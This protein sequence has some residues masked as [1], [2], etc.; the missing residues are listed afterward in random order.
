MTAKENFEAFL[1]LQAEPGYSLGDIEGSKEADM[2]KYTELKIAVAQEEA[3]EKDFSVKKEAA[4][5]AL[6]ESHSQE[7]IELG[8]LWQLKE[9]AGF[10]ADFVP[11]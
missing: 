11:K 3:K 6:R 4:F 7:M 9:D 1:A 2:E 5:Q 10:D 8:Q